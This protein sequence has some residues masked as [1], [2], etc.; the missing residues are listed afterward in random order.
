MTIR[1]PLSQAFDNWL[2]WLR[3]EKKASPHTIEAYERDVRDFLE[4]I[5]GYIGGIVELEDLEN[6]RLAD[7]R[8]YLAQRRQGGLTASSLRRVLSSIRSFYKRQERDGYLHNP[9]LKTLRSPRSGARLPRPLNAA[10]TRELLQKATTATEP[11][12]VRHRDTAVLTLL[13]GCGLRIGEALS[14]NFDDRPVSHTLTLI[15]KGNKERMVPVLPV[16]IEA[17]EAYVCECPFPLDSKSPLFI[18]RQ[19]RRL[20]ARAIQLKMQNLRRNMNLPETATPHALRHSFATHLLAGGSDLRSIQEL[21]GHA[22]LSSTQRYTD[23]DVE[24]L[25]EVYDSSH[26]KS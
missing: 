12:W 5:S 1:P 26:P 15:G 10:D 6:L 11:L 23:L 22:S 19:G 24:K 17:V 18:G 20:N 4:F 3:H 8:A 21:L 14:L 13:Y 16:V 9:Y 2:G 7:F 25:L